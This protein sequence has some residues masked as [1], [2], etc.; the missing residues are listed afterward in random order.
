V[1]DDKTGR[2]GSSGT[3]EDAGQG[4]LL[5]EFLDDY[6]SEDNPVRVID[7]F[8]DELDWRALAR[9]AGEPT[10]PFFALRAR[11]GTAFRTGKRT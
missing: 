6:V 11:S 2:Y 5:P 1:V 3:R 7:A 4:G 8:A 10:F 9:P